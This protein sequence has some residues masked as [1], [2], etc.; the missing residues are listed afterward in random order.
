M[1]FLT[2][3]PF[4][5]ACTLVQSELSE[6]LFPRFFPYLHFIAFYSK[7]CWANLSGLQRMPIRHVFKARGLLFVHH[8]YTHARMLRM[9]RATSGFRYN[10]NVKHSNTSHVSSLWE[11]T[12]EYA[13]ARARLSSRSGSFHSPAEISRTSHE[14]VHLLYLSNIYMCFVSL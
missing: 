2:R 7:G 3:I 1:L 13:S 14:R 5:C 12:P 8:V 10:A 6:L 4:F 9:L 11:R